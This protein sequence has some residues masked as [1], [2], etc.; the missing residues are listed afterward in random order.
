MSLQDQFACS[1]AQNVCEPLEQSHVK[2]IKVTNGS[3]EY[4][5]LTDNLLAMQSLEK[6]YLKAVDISYERFLENTK[7]C[8]VL[9]INRNRLEPIEELTRGLEV[10]NTLEKIEILSGNGPEHI[11][12][13]LLV[14]GKCK[15]LKCVRLVHT[16]DQWNATNHIA[17]LIEETPLAASGVE[18]L[19]I[20]VSRNAFPA[21]C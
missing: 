17:K 1:T 5:A 8:K 7:T 20:Q 12:F 10:N 14:L 11:F 2:K 4:L 16:G 6:L 13:S 18:V 19:Y 15:T 3:S 9:N 21:F